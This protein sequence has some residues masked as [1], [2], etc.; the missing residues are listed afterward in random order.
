MM[1]EKSAVQDL[2]YKKNI[3]TFMIVG[4]FST[5]LQLVNLQVTV[6]LF[7]LAY[8]KLVTICF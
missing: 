7:H 6:M 1:F 5:S 2:N 4:S 8:Q 3:Q